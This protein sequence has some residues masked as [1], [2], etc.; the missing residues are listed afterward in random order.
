MLGTGLSDTQAHLPIGSSLLTFTG[1]WT[2]S[3]CVC[4]LEAPTVVKKHPLL[5][6]FLLAELRKIK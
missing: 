6:L 3:P 1:Q 5:L 4:L 2:V